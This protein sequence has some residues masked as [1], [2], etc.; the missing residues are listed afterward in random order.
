MAIVDRGSMVD[1]SMDNRGSMVG[2]GVNSGMVCRDMVKGVISS[3]VR[4][5]GISG[6]VGRG[7][8]KVAISSIAISSIPSV[9]RAMGISSM[10]GRGS[11][12]IA[13]CFLVIS[14]GSIIVSIVH[15]GSMVDRAMD[16]RGSVCMVDRGMLHSNILARDQGNQSGDTKG[17]LKKKY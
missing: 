9:V 1:G 5:M 11:I 6:M 2:R 8:A 14:V 4:P 7:M 3:I 13:V 17:G 10:E 15:R 12:V 16:H